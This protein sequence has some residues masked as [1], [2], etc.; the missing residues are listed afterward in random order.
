MKLIGWNWETLGERKIGSHAEE[1]IPKHK[2][3]GQQRNLIGL[4]APV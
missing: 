1:A 2:K 4:C 3:Y